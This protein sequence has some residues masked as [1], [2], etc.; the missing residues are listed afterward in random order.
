MKLDHITIRTTD[1]AA[2]RHFFEAFFDLVEQPRPQAI[3]HIPGHW[4]FADEEPIVHLVGSMGTSVARAADAIDHIALRIDDYEDFRTRLDDSATAYSTMELPE[5]NERRLFLCA[6]GGPL[7]EAVYR[8]TH[9]NTQSAD[10]AT[11]A[12]APDLAE[13]ASQIDHETCGE[14]T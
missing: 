10:K 3:R 1:L 12:A 14:A 7:I 8:Q 9:I 2:T 11:H 6:P 5:L 4:L 13:L